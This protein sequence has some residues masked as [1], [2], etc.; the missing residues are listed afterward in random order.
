MGKCTIFLTAAALGCL[1]TA[2]CGDSKGKEAAQPQASEVAEAPD[3]APAA[4]LE[5]I[6]KD[7]TAQNILSA[8][9]IGESTNEQVARRMSID[10]AKAKLAKAISAQLQAHSATPAFAEEAASVSLPGTTVHTSVTQ[11]SGESGT[12]RVYSLITTKPA[13]ETAAEHGKPGNKAD[14]DDM[15]RKLDANI[16]EYEAKYKR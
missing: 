12:Y 5:A 2:G 11:Y 15:M 10:N 1:L 8:I 16:A 13:S 3:S 7:L 9:G 14:L 6:T 4:E